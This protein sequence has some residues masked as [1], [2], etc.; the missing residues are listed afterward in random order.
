MDQSPRMS[1]PAQRIKELLK[2]L[3][4]Y[5]RIVDEYFVSYKGN[6][7]YFDF[8][9]PELN[10]LV[11]VQ[12]QQHYNFVE[13]FHGTAL[14]FTQSKKRDRLKLDYAEEHELQVV[15]IDSKLVK[16]L[17]SKLLLRLLHGDYLDKEDLKDAK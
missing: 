9:I 7:L 2:E 5:Y 1:A 14:G 16:K 15:C 13:H 10:I 8:Y 6:K 4:P 17:T 12:G 11:E 3:F